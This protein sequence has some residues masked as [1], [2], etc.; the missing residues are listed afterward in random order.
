MIAQSLAK[1]V[2]CELMSIETITLNEAFQNLQW[3]L[4]IKWSLITNISQSNDDTY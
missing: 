1:N 4:K 3:A 2:Y